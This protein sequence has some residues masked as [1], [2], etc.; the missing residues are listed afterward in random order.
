M[1]GY[2][3]PDRD[4]GLQGHYAG[5]FTRLAAFVMDV[6]AIVI[7]FDIGGNVVEYL[8]TALS[9]NQFRLSE[10]PIVAAVALAAWAFLY[11]AY[12]LAVNGRTFGMAVAGLRV[13]R[14]DGTPLDTRHAVL[15][16]LAFPLSFLVLGIG[17]LMILLHRD[18]RALHD[19]IAKTAVVYAWD[20]RAARLRFLAKR[21]L[22]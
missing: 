1:S 22:E 9:G 11:C 19:L 2:V 21:T 8:V 10:H 17:F 14:S 18:G 4:V 16:V 5:F 12:P 20:A 13:V 7:L 15:R 3:A 6:L